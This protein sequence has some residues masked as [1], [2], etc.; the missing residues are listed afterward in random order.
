MR[1][2]L[3]ILL[4]FLVS[5]VGNASETWVP[6]ELNCAMRFLLM[7]SALLLCLANMSCSDLP[8]S[9][10]P[11]IAIVQGA[12]TAAVRNPQTA[13]YAYALV[14]IDACVVNHLADIGDGSFHASF[15]KGRG[16]APTVLVGRGDVLQL[17][18]FE[19]KER[20]SIHTGRIWCETR[21]L[22]HATAHGRESQ[23]LHRC[24][25]HR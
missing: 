12:A 19:I 5:L 24:T 17:T 15:G 18:I 16:S 23:R 20:R 10:P 1:F 7:P 3:T 2:L 8:L 22:R 13:A 9:G 6:S 4:S 11:D 14:D 25:V 21:Q